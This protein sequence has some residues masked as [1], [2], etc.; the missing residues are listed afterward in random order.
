[1]GLELKLSPAVL[2]PRPETEI[3]VE[4]ALRVI[5]SQG[6]KLTSILDIGT[7]SGCIA[8]SLAKFLPYAR[9][10]ATDIS[11]EA[12]E[13]ARQ[14]AVLN[15]IAGRVKFLLANLF[16]ASQTQP[17]AYSLII[18]NPPY[19]PTAE[20]SSLDSELGY[21]PRVALDGGRDGLDFYRRI[22]SEAPAYFGKHGFLILEIGFNQCLAIKDLFNSN[23]RFQI[24]EVVQDY[25]H[26]HRVIV[27]RYG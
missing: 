21:E 27:A 17:R 5:R 10:T 26:I 7:G 14:N 3:L 12:L 20:M 9:I 18:S 2:I 13:I 8:I 22:I 15:N 23:G 11:Q 25:N 24:I 1:M 16:P 6:H 19:I 4:T